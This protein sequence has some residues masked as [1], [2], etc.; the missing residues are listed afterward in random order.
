MPVAY[1]TLTDDEVSYDCIGIF[2]D[3]S[4]K[5][6]VLVPGYDE[7]MSKVQKKKP[8]SIRGAKIIS[9]KIIK[10]MMEDRGIDTIG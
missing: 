8:K 7:F 10:Q 1:N 3:N 9:T 6:T 5:A 4:L 2:E